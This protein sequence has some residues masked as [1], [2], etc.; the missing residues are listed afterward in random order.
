MFSFLYSI[1]FELNMLLNLDYYS[2]LYSIK[3]I[4]L[5]V[6][7]VSGFGA[8]FRLMTRTTSFRPVITFL[9]Y[10]RCK[11]YLFGLFFLFAVAQ[12]LQFQLFFGAN[13]A[14]YLVSASLSIVPLLLSLCSDISVVGVVIAMVCRKYD[15]K[16]YSLLILL[17][18]VLL[19]LLSY[20]ITF[21]R[22]GF[23]RVI[24]PIILYRIASPEVHKCIHNGVSYVK[25]ELTMRMLSLRRLIFPML[26]WFSAFSVMGG[27]MRIIRGNFSSYSFSFDGVLGNLFGLHGNNGM[28]GYTDYLMQL[29]RD[30]PVRTPYLMGQSYYRLLLLPIPRYFYNK[31][32]STQRIIG[33]IL[34]PDI[35]NMTIPPGVSGDAYI[36]FG[37]LGVFVA[38][39]FAVLFKWFDNKVTMSKFFVLLC[40]PY[41]ILHLIRGSLSGCIVDL[42]FISVPIFFLFNE[43]HN[44]YL[45]PNSGG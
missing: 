4:F 30:F 22:G 34:R 26:F 9:S 42:L 45:L 32:Q 15:K 29:V 8:L 31:P 3:N 39:V 35:S 40:S 11:F 12:L 1:T 36:N 2:N 44:N 14:K 18:Y 25:I 23:F 28:L 7:V 20:R 41:F 24:F 33:H 16:I 37:V 38:L 10:R 27:I 43:K 17:G 19:S 21:S 6:F 13:R 5:A